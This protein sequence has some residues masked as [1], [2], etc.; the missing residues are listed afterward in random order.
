VGVG[1]AG[2][3]AGEPHAPAGG[4]PNPQPP[5]EQLGLF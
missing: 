2:A 4:A 3:P 5:G 1:G